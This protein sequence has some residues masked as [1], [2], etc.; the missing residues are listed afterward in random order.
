ML[1]LHFTSELLFPQ[2]LGAE[3]GAEHPSGSEDEGSSQED[4]NT[5]Q[6]S[7]ERASPGSTWQTVNQVLVSDDNSSDE[8]E[9]CEEDEEEDWQTCSEDE[10]GDNIDAV[11]PER[12]ES[13]T[14]GAAVQHGVQEQNRNVRNFSHLVQRNELLEIFKTMHDGPRVKDGEVNVGLVSWTLCLNGIPCAPHGKNSSCSLASYKGIKTRSTNHC[15]FC[16]KINTEVLG[17]QCAPLFALVFLVHFVKELLCQSSVSLLAS[18]C[19][20]LLLIFHFF[21]I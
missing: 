14:D 11:A 6:G 12:M 21:V 9:D 19:L 10:A 13:R 18:P 17:A 20:I 5:A 7:T 1:S 2:E 4:D 3:G 16:A 8:Y 15:G